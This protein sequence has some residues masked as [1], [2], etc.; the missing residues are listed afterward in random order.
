M[1]ES[2]GQIKRPRTAEKIVAY[3][4]P[5]MK[6]KAAS[7]NVACDGSTSDMRCVQNVG[8]VFGESGRSASPLLPRFVLSWC[9]TGAGNE[10]DSA[11][12]DS[13]FSMIVIVAADVQM[14]GI[15]WESE[16]LEGLFSGMSLAVR[17]PLKWLEMGSFFSHW[18]GW[19]MMVI[20]SDVAGHLVA[21]AESS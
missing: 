11:R 6:Q 10:P 12:E 17:S 16:M 15:S 20:G 1:V 8:L 4:K 13:T 19:S 9:D 5:V 2:R 3:M 7:G 14:R 21:D 18:R